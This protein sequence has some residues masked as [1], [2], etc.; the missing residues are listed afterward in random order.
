MIKLALP[1][2]YRTRCQMQYGLCKGFQTWTSYVGVDRTPVPHS[3]VSNFISRSTVV[4]P[5]FFRSG[6]SNLV[7]LSSPWPVFNL[8]LI[9][10]R[11]LPPLSKSNNSI[12]SSVSLDPLLAL[13]LLCSS[14]MIH[15]VG[16]CFPL[17]RDPPGHPCFPEFWE[18]KQWRLSLSPPLGAFVQHGS[19]QLRR[20]F[21]ARNIWWYWPRT[22][23]C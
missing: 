8:G 18:L 20:W 13:V 15:V 23:R 16:G 19:Q 10:F 7:K 1:S 2:V 17:R 4:D 9:V 21:W 5:S 12:F 3:C 14:S 22:F 11:L 6:I